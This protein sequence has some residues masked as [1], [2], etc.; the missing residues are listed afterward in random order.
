M[1]SNKFLQPIISQPH[2]PPT[3]CNRPAKTLFL[4]EERELQQKKFLQLWDWG[5]QHF[6]P[7]GLHVSNL[8]GDLKSHILTRSDDSSS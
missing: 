7:L 4:Q 6:Q 1:N 2:P 5:K 3:L 8:P